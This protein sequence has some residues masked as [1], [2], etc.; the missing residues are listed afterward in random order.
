MNGYLA[1]S[2]YFSHTRITACGLFITAFFFLLLLL[3]Y[4]GS[5][6]CPCTVLVPMLSCSASS[7]KPAK[8][9]ARAAGE[10]CN[11]L[12][13]TDPPIYLVHDIMALVFTTMTYLREGRM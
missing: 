3:P 8:S 12:I 4:T 2:V 10:A 1:L 6:L 13:V 11:R 5:C 9:S 7:A